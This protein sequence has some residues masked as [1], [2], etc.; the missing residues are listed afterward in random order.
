MNDNTP[1]DFMSDDDSDIHP[2][3]AH[4]TLMYCKEVSQMHLYEVGNPYPE[5]VAYITSAITQ[6]THDEGGC[7]HLLLVYGL[8]ESYLNAEVAALRKVAQ[9]R[10]K[11]EKEEADALAVIDY[12]RKREAAVLYLPPDFAPTTTLNIKTALPDMS[13]EEPFYSQDKHLNEIRGWLIEVYVR[14]IINFNLLLQLEKKGRLV[15]SAVD[16]YLEAVEEAQYELE[17]ITRFLNGMPN[18]S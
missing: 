5:N 7:K 2:A 8:H 1:N 16:V 4:R 13:T 17:D 14:K 3:H 10:V 6:A 11:A 9:N 15:G 18:H 12:E